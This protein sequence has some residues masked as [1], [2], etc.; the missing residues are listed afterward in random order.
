MDLSPKSQFQSL[1]KEYCDAF[2]K[3]ITEPAMRVGLTSAFAQLQFGG[4]TT[5]EMNGAKKFIAI[6]AALGEPPASNHLPSKE[7]KTL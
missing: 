3:L 6:L 4:V 1:H 5:E 7:L 2:C